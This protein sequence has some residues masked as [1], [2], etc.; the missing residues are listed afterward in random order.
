[1]CCSFKGDL[2]YSYLYTY[3]YVSLLQ[4][5]DGVPVFEAAFKYLLHFKYLLTTFSKQSWSH[6]TVYD[7]V[8]FFSLNIFGN[9]PKHF[10]MSI[11]NLL[12]ILFWRGE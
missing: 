2:P 6:Y 10:L 11:N 4:A 12:L 5:K 3:T 7:F 1:M 9:I 8:L